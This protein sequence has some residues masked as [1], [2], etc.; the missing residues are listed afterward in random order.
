MTAAHNIVF[1][2]G[3]VLMTFDGMYFSRVFTE[4]EQDAQALYE[5]LFGRTE[6]ALLDAGAI[7]HDTMLRVAEAHTPERLLPNLHECLAHWP[8][9]SQVIGGTNALAARLKA[10]GWGVYVLS[11]ASTRV[12]EQLDQAPV[13]AIADGVV[14]SA[15]ERVMKPDPAI[16]A[17]LCDRYGIA[18][19]T[20]IFVDDNLDNCKGAAVAGMHPFHFTGDVS[21]LE[22]FIADE[23]GAQT[24]IQTHAQAP[25][26]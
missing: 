3:N 8:E 11:N 7:D 10:A 21:A 23:A 18:P 24:Q 14:V 1:D 22:D 16:F 4:C 26:N 9:H 13:A 5:G 2:M 12:R 6:W 25:A 19:D 20:C 17:L 15:F